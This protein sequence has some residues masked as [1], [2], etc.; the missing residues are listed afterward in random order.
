MKRAIALCRRQ[1]KQLKNYVIE[2]VFYEDVSEARANGERVRSLVKPLREWESK[3]FT[4]V[5]PV[6]N[7]AVAL[8]IGLCSAILLIS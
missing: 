7:K 4:H 5:R 3:W 8:F 2:A 1:D 6:F